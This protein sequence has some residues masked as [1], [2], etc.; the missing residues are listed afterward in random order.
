MDDGMSR[1]L[2]L[3]LLPVAACV[4]FAPAQAAP[5]VKTVT[6][7]GSVAA[8][9]SISGKATTVSFGAV[10]NGSGAYTGNGSHLDAQDDAAFCNQGHTSALIQRTN[11]KTS[12]SAGSG[13]TNVIPMSASLSTTEGAT[14]SDSS[15]DPGTGTSTG[16]SGQIN[17][18]T[19]L[20]VTATLGSI[21]ANRPVAGTYTGTITITL[22][23]GS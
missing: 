14:L 13:F 19:G 15:A 11:L 18:F 20:K 5:T 3:A 21:G 22:T 4:G 12:N 9:C 17:A 6:A 8:S 7:T 23:P 16:T 10:T 1:N 2:K